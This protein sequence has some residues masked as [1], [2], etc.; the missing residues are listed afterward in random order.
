MRNI[1]AITIC[2]VA[3]LVSAKLPEPSAAVLA[4]AK[5]TAAKSAWSDKRAQYQLCLSQDRTAES[6]RRG[7]KA[8]GKPVPTQTTTVAC[9]DP[10]PYAPPPPIA[11]RPLEASGAHSPPETAAAPPS[12]NVPAAAAKK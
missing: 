5:E 6:Y 4:Q 12:T 8:E 2:L 10:G 3:G 1:L 11:A 9:A 7:L